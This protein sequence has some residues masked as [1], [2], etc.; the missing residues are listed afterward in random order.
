MGFSSNTGM[1]FRTRLLSNSPRAEIRCSAT[2]SRSNW[3]SS[4]WG[5]SGGGYALDKVVL[6]LLRFCADSKGIEDAGAEGVSDGFRGPIAKI[7]LAEDLHA[8]D[9]LSLG[10]HLLDYA[11]DDV[12]IG[13]H[14]GANRIETNEID[15]DPWRGGCSAQ[16]LKA[17]AGDAVGSND[18]LLLGL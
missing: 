15:I 12:G 9:A 16:G 8:D 3:E 1:S 14:M 4:R 6:F 10:S 17:V 7:S 11:D 18:A 2:C 13:I 5:V